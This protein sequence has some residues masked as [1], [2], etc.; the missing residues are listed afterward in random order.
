M[1]NLKDFEILTSHAE[2][3]PTAETTLHEAA[4]LITAAIVFAREQKVRKLML[5]ITGLTGFAPPNLATRYFFFQEW[6]RAAQGQVSVV[7]V[8]RPEMIDPEKIGILIAENAGLRGDAFTNREEALAW[9]EKL[10]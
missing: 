2:F 4:Q 6:A 10:E 3:R 5:D 9:L 1:I 8:A 7:F